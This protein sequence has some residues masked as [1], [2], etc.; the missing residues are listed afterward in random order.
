MKMCMGLALLSRERGKEV[1]EQEKQLLKII[2]HI[3]RMI[4]NPLMI[5]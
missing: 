2:N 1:H 4:Y 3:V 5:T